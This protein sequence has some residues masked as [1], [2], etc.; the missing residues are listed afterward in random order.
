MNLIE[1]VDKGKPL[2]SIINCD[3]L[4]G[5]KQ[6]ESNSVDLCFFD[7]PYNRKKDYGVYKDNMPYDEYMSFVKQFMRETQRISKNG[8][9]IFVAN[10][11]TKL[12]WDI[13][14]NAKL[15]IIKK[16]SPGFGSKNLFECWHSILT[17]AIPNK[18]I[19]DM[20]EDIRLPGEGYFYKEERT[21]NPGQT[22]LKLTK[23]AISFLSN[24]D[25]IVLD[26]FMGCGTTAIVCK[27][28]KRNFVGFELNSVYCKNTRERL[29]KQTQE[30]W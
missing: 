12:F 10:N 14:P 16:Y 5:M 13:I 4:E 15:I 1:W 27:Q 25:D 19:P 3:C 21:T 2:N 26:P 23:T 24:A 9:C 18:N 8:I 17:T 28:L 6:M 30:F 20:W 22:S 11:L 7:P 29:N